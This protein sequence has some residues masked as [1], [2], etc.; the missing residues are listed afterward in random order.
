[1]NSFQTPE[2]NYEDTEIITNNINQ[3]SINGNNIILKIQRGYG[4]HSFCFICKRKTGS[5]PMTVLPIESIVEIY[6]KREILIPLG[7]RS[8]SDHL[9]ENNYVKDNEIDNIP[10]ADV[11]IGLT[12]EKIEKLFQGFKS[13]E[14]KCRMFS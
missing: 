6:N 2:S 3:A 5:K 14:K 12:P 8:C 9:S 13:R 11:S 4:S 7:A 10:I 1:M